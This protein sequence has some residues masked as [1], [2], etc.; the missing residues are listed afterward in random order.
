[1][2][3]LIYA[4]H[5]MTSI[6]QFPLCM[7]KVREQEGKL[8]KY[9]ENEKGFLAEIKNKLGNGGKLLNIYE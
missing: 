2:R 7:E 9:L 3:L 4:R 5:I 1:M 6:H 8:Q